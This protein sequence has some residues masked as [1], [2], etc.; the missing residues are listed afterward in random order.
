MYLV[1]CNF[2][3]IPSCGFSLPPSVVENLTGRT[4]RFTHFH[5]LLRSYESG[6]LGIPGLWYSFIDI[7]SAI[8]AGNGQTKIIYYIRKEKETPFGVSFSF[9]NQQLPILP[10]RFQPSTFGV[11]ELNYCVRD[12]NRWFLVAIITEFVRVFPENYIER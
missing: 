3:F 5:A 2:L 12:G 11:Y 8:L 6:S 4:P 9:L 7:T 10:G 1:I